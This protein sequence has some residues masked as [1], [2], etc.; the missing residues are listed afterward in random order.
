MTQITSESDGDGDLGTLI[1]VSKY[2]SSLTPRDIHTYNSSYLGGLGYGLQG[3]DS[4][5]MGFFEAKSKWGEGKH[6]FRSKP[7]PLMPLKDY[8]SPDFVGIVPKKSWENFSLYAHRHYRINVGTAY[9]AYSYV[10]FACSKEI[11]EFRELCFSHIPDVSNTDIIQYLNDVSKLDG[12]MKDDR[13]PP[14]YRDQIC[15]K[16]K[17]VIKHLVSLCLTS[18]IMYEGMG[19]SG[20]TYD[21]YSVFSLYL[22]LVNNSSRKVIPYIDEDF[23]KTKV[24][25]AKEN[26][27]LL[28]DV[29]PSF[30]KKSQS[31]TNLFKSALFPLEVIKASEG[32]LKPED[33]IYDPLQDSYMT[34]SKG[35][36]PGL[37]DESIN[38]ILKA[39][40]WGY[41]YQRIRGGLPYPG[42]AEDALCAV[43]Y[44]VLRDFTSGAIGNEIEEIMDRG[45]TASMSLYL[46]N[47]INDKENEYKE[48]IYQLIPNTQLREMLLRAL[49]L[50]TLVY[51]YKQSQ[52]ASL[53]FM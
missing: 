17:D 53:Q 6:L 18:R 2:D 47:L 35:L 45:P 15:T 32:S 14:R 46:W 4:T 13:I 12:L 20:F 28:D 41:I 37:C 52:L 44:R 31:G 22:A 29:L 16:G 43:T 42:T 10:C 36:Y 40:L 27:R 34:Y 50:I 11:E 9:G 51:Q 48:S 8:E 49:P 5:L 21:A 33:S 38:L 19:L 25:Y 23:H 7:H 3:K 1:A 24:L 30:I 26:D 39:G